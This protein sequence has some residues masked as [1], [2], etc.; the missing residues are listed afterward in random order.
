MKYTDKFDNGNA[1]KGLKRRNIRKMHYPGFY[2]TIHHIGRR[3]K[4]TWVE[5]RP[6]SVSAPRQQPKLPDVPAEIVGQPAP[7]G[8]Y[9]GVPTSSHVAASHYDRKAK[10]VGEWAAQYEPS[11]LIWLR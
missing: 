11:C 8:A 3:P 7:E 4:T 10:V 1:K 9:S 5:K 6:Y 2:S